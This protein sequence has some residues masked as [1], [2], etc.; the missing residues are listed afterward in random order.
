MRTNGDNPEAEWVYMPNVKVR[1]VQHQPNYAPGICVNVG[2]T[3]KA[4]YP[5]KILKHAF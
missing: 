3:Y 5:E 2:I 1:D 4:R